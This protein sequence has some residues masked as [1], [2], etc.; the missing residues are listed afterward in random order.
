SRELNLEPILDI[1]TELD[2]IQAIEARLQECAVG[3]NIS[4]HLSADDGAQFLGHVHSY[5]P[6]KPPSRARRRVRALDRRGLSS[7]D[8]IAHAHVR[9]NG[10]DRELPLAAAAAVIPIIHLCTPDT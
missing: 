7:R 6:K 3:R 8:G 1:E 9:R 10:K 2:H 5:C 4:L